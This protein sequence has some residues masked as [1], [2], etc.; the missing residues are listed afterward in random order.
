MIIIP[1]FIQVVDIKGQEGMKGIILAGGKSSRLLPASHCISK[2]LLPVYDKPM[3]YYSLSTL[4]LTGLKEILII[5]L[6]HELAMFER[7]LGDGSA[8]G[9]S[10][11]YK[12]QAK[13][14]GIAEAFIIGEEFIGDDTVALMLGDNI[15]YGDNLSNKLMQAATLTTGAIVFSYYVADPKRYGIIIFNETQNPIDIV[16]KPSSPLSHY[17]VIGLY[18]YDNHVIE[19]AKQ[20]QP[21]LRGELEITDISRYYLSRNMLRVEKLSRGT[22]WLDTGTPKS[23]LEAANFIYVLEERQGLKIGCPEE[24]AWR[25]G[26]IDTAQLEKLGNLQTKSGYGE[27]LLNLLK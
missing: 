21:S 26:F 8:F 22:A 3:I 7:L 2:Q 25:M 10:L 9:I 12:T 18:F 19:I 6:P 13:P 17:A 15:L 5:T 23:L 24:V 27:Y 20:L 1:T 14:A 4:M 11:S 16:E